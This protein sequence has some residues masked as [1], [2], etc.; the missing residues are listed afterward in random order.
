MWLGFPSHAELWAEDLDA[1]QH[2]VAALARALAGPG[3]ERVRLLVQGDDAAA[4]ARRLLGSV[5][6]IE[7]VRGE[8]G[9]IWLR[10]TG[11]IFVEAGEARFRAEAF[12]FNGWGGK[13]ELQGDEA[14]AEQIA[15]ASACAAGPARLHPRG[16]RARPRRLRHRADHSS[17]PA[18]SQPQSGLDRGQRR[19][20]A[21]RRLGRAQGG[22]AG[23]GPGQRPHRRPRRQPG[24]FRRARRG[25]LPGGRGR[26]RPARGRL[27]RSGPRAGLG[28]RRARAP[29]CRWCASPRPAA[30]RPTA[31]SSPPAT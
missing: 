25:R 3:L 12:R 4:A 28:H 17:V 22:L 31:K 9:D 24:P 29:S 14:V 26:R 19:G 30:S 6:E 11:P 7:I 5:T 1:A 15:A 20:G 21:G 16:R 27:R 23:R 18:Q 2:E 8:F 10:D 13:Y